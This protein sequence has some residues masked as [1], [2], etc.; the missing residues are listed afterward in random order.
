TQISILSLH[1]ALPIYKNDYDRYKHLTGVIHMDKIINIEDVKWIKGGQEILKDINW[2][3]NNGEH[4]AVLGLNGSGKTSLLNI[5]TG[6]NY[7]TMG[8]V[9][10]LDTTFGKDRKST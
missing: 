6:Y 2:T 10:I 9:T 8:D 5:V 7:P 4:W 3:V 1:D